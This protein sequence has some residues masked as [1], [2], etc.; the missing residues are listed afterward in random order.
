MV[1]DFGYASEK[2]GAAVRILMLPHV[3]EASSV[4][5]AIHEISLAL[6]P[7]SDLGNDEANRWR[8]TI[9]RIMSTESVE[10]PGGEGLWVVRA[11]QLTQVEK[12]QFS[13]CV[14]ELQMYCNGEYYEH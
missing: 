6:K 13:R 1:V 9:F 10:D 7:E 2:L 12:H 14:W 5:S 8:D 11:R 4:A 3:D